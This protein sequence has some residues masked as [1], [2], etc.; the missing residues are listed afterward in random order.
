MAIP[1]FST[2]QQSINSLCQAVKRAIRQWT[3]PDNHG[4]VFN[5]VLDLAQPRSELA[6]E[7]ALLRQQLIVLQR[8]VKRPKMTRRD[9]V[10]MVLLAS[11]LQR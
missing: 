8:Q 11:K 10:L 7:N 6:L 4:L 9:R 3:R 2:V 5:A 1:L